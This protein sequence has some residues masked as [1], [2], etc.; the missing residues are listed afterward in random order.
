MEKHKFNDILE[1][2]LKNK[3]EENIKIQTYQKYESLIRL[4]LRETIGKLNCYELNKEK[5][6]KF[7]NSDKI[8]VLSNSTKKAIFII[9]KSAL[10]IA[11]NN[12]YCDYIDLRKIKFKQKKSEIIVF[13]KSEQRK[14]D[15]Y[16]MTDINVRKLVLLICMYTGIRVGEASG[17]KWKDIDFNKKTINIERTIQRIKNP[18]KQSNKKTILIASTPK[19]ESSMRT[20]PIPEFLI[21]IL[22][23][24]KQND[25][26]YI[27]SES[28][29]IYDLRLLESCFERT[30]KICNIRYLKFHTL[31]HS[32]ATSSIEA[33][34]DIK[35]LSEILGHASVEIT[36]KL[37]VHPTYNMKKK[38]IEK[39]TKFI[40]K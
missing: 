14:I 35:T 15:N 28:E 20:I 29:K 40:K 8:I 21:S 22:K 2:W 36:L 38:S 4:Y 25:N 13:T 17:L 5:I 23:E 24:F 34:I 1:I 9:I 10:E 30:L 12:K 11:Y 39:T 16:L 32:F 6:I 7:F 37:Y 19:S 3:K 31:R 26:Y 27:L 18:D 33:G